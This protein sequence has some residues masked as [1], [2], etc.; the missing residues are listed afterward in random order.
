M[1]IRPVGSLGQSAYKDKLIIKV[2]EKCDAFTEWY[3]TDDEI[4]VDE[5]DS[6]LNFRLSVHKTIEESKEKVVLSMVVTVNNAIGK[7]Y[8]S[9]ILPFHKIVMKAYLDRAKKNR[10]M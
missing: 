3:L 7:M 6:H 2:G 8:L 5:D 4:V 1:T 9:L 10:Y